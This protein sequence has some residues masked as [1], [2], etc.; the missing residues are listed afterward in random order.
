[1]FPNIF[2]CLPFGG[3]FG[4]NTM[5]ADMLDCTEESHC[6]PALWGRNW[7]CADANYTRLE[8]NRLQYQPPTLTILGCAQ[9][10]FYDEGMC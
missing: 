3:Q 8:S 4:A 5:P 6:Q 10:E 2:E 7:C 1:M 9:C